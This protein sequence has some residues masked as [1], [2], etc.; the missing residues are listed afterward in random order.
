MLLPSTPAR[1]GEGQHEEGWEL[2]GKNPRH[3]AALVFTGQ[4]AEE[5]CGG[6]EPLQP[7]ASPWNSGLPPAPP[8]RRKGLRAPISPHPHPE[9]VL[10]SVPSDFLPPLNKIPGTQLFGF[11]TRRVFVKTRTRKGGGEQGVII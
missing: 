4:Q 10:R 8:E 7:P 6:K 2:G 11:P 9:P 3:H 5:G 1:Q